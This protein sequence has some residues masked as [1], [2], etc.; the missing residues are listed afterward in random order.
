MVSDCIQTILSKKYNQRK[1]Q[2]WSVNGQSMTDETISVE[3]T[4]EQN[5][6]LAVFFLLG[7]AL[8]TLGCFFFFACSI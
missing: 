5:N 3:K 4:F 2:Q 8:K 7:L 1:R 6:L